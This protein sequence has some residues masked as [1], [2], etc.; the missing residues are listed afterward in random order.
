MAMHAENL[1]MVYKVSTYSVYLESSLGMD[2]GCPL[3]FFTLFLHCSEL[4]TFFF[5]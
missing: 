5:F 2:A 1:P 4:G 3:S